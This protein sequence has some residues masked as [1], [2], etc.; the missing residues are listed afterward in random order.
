[1]LLWFEVVVYQA[2]HFR[3]AFSCSFDA[4]LCQRHHVVFKLSGLG[5]VS[6]TDLEVHDW[7]VLLLDLLLEREQP[8]AS[9]RAELEIEVAPI[10]QPHIQRHVVYWICFDYYRGSTV[11][12]R[13]SL[14][15]GIT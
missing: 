1:M 8:S 11:E 12:Q 10:E 3:L 5:K 14:D 6:F 9:L 7:A 2:Y 15:T 4:K 13:A